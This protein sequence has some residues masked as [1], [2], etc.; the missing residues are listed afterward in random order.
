MNPSKYPIKRLTVYEVALLK[1]TCDVLIMFLATVKVIGGEKDCRWW[2][3]PEKESFLNLISAQTHWPRSF[4]ANFKERFPAICLT[5]ERK[6]HWEVVRHDKKVDTGEIG[7]GFKVAKWLS[8]VILLP[9]AVNK[10]LRATQENHEVTYHF[11]YRASK[12]NLT[13]LHEW[14]SLQNSFIK[15]WKDI[16]K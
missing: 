10:H 1:V 13:K 12:L 3:D 8:Q 4:E 2:S 15:R 9:A 11:G 14:G 5:E 16:S 7:A 6:K